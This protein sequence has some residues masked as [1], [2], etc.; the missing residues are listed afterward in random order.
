MKPFT[1]GLK[2]P[3]LIEID[4]S[5]DYASALLDVLRTSAA[6]EHGASNDCSEIGVDCPVRIT[7]ELKHRDEIIRCLEA[8]L[9][10]KKK[11]KRKRKRRASAPRAE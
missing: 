3:L 9:A 5:H 2:A 4:L 8:E 10:P 11:R 6:R 7:V 1:L